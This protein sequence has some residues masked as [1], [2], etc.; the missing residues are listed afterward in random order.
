MN[1]VIRIP[2]HQ[3]RIKLSPLPMDAKLRCLGNEIAIRNG[4][5][6]YAFI[7]VLLVNPLGSEFYAKGMYF[8]VES[9]TKEDA[10][11]NMPEKVLGAT[12]QQIWDYNYYICIL[13]TKAKNEL[14][15]Q[16]NESSP[17]LVFPRDGKE[18]RTCGYPQDYP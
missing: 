2:H 12:S 14:A 8:A 6:N 9:D 5:I 18:T 1:S 7:V 10:T 3:G 15:R 11:F 4:I 13:L 16:I 17:D